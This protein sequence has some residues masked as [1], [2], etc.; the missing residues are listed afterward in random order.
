MGESV[1]KCEYSAIKYLFLSGN[2]TILYLLLFPLA[3]IYLA[4]NFHDMS[5]TGTT[6][7]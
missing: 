7:T 5:I 4:G 2:Y 1:V 3:V 6:Q